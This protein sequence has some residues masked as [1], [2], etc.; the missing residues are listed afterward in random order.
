MDGARRFSS[1]DH[2]AAERAARWGEFIAQGR[3][4][5]MVEPLG[6]GDFEGVITRVVL[7]SIEVLHL[8]AGPHRL[9]L[10]PLP[11]QGRVRIVVQARGSATFSQGGER[12]KLR[13]GEWTIWLTDRPHSVVNEAAVE[14]FVILIPQGLLGLSLASILR[15]AGT[16][17]GGRPGIGR[18]LP[19]F[20]RSLAE[21]LEAVP[22]AFHGELAEILAH[23]VR[24]ALEEAAGSHAPEARRDTMRGRVTDY[25]RHHLRDPDLSVG[26]IATSI[27]CSKRNIH[28]LFKDSGST[29]SQF[30]WDERLDR[31][32]AALADP[33]SAGRS[34][35]EIAF[36]WGF[37]NSSHFSR[38]FKAR[39]GSS[40]GRWRSEAIAH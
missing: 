19:P 12:L 34:V 2:P 32:R 24:L 11:A 31:C 30:V 23:H 8:Q 28:N 1:G 40:P 27:G 26:Q 18:M 16:R 33:A 21:Q 10:G 7:A 35:T 4:Q 9:S 37:S 13:A 25:V 6:D 15:H 5:L 22:A 38:L 29:V 3:A 39:F 17:L 36:A 14:Q 20:L